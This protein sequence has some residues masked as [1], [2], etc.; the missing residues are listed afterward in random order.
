M[1]I[2]THEFIVQKTLRVSE[3]KDRLKIRFPFKED[4]PGNV[5]RTYQDTFDWRLYNRQLTYYVE[6][7]QGQLQTTLHDMG[8]GEQISLHVNQAPRFAQDIQ[9]VILRKK[10]ASLLDVR[11]LVDHLVVK[12]RRHPM[13]YVDEEQKAL[14]HLSIDEYRLVLPGGKS[15]VLD[16]RVCV[17]PVKGYEKPVSLLSRYLTKALDLVPAEESVFDKGARVSG[18]DPGGYS[19]QIK[20]RFNSDLR[21]DEAIKDVLLSSLDVMEANE[22]GVVNDIDTEFLHDFRVAVRRSRSILSQ[23]KG[24]FPKKVLDRFVPGLKWLGSITGPARDVH[25]Y[26]LK[27]ESYQQALPAEMRPHLDPLYTFLEKHEGMEQSDLAKQLTSN[28]Y[29]TF[30]TA[31]RDYL[32]MPVPERTSLPH[33]RQ[34]VKQTADAQIWKAYQRVMNQGSAITAECADEKLHR[35]RISCKKL[36]YLLEFFQS[37][38]PAAK[39]KILIKSLK[40]L[41]DI[42]GDFNDFSVQ[43]DSLEHL[44]QQMEEEGMLP[45]DT[46]K[47]MMMLEQHF[48]ERMQGQ[49]SLFKDSF[50]RFSSKQNRD[51]FRD[52]CKLTIAGHI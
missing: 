18:F 28:R 45:P 22:G 31:W 7:G 16:K 30:K 15:R 9:S 36:R 38:Y 35:L 32:Q 41:Q 40:Q 20:F 37:L 14:A 3:L 19:S 4:A 29:K 21:T 13:R 26:L 12:I 43:I 49:R 33:A 44:Q 51:L 50:A 24:V 23:V 39:M 5:T 27:F 47:A 2:T 6:S 8:T 46:H 48:R 1:G 42:L 10:I 25:V 17:E 11:A 34:T 52:L